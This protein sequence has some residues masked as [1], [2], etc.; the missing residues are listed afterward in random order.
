MALPDGEA[1]FLGYGDEAEALLA[2]GAQVDGGGQGGAV[3][4]H[5]AADE[6]LPVAGDGVG[7]G[8]D[9]AQ[10]GFHV[11]QHALGAQAALDFF[12]EGL[13]GDLPMV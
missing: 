9:F 4:Y 3:G 5:G 13:D 8:G 10:L 11:H 1:V 7:E 12:A 2:T 6:L